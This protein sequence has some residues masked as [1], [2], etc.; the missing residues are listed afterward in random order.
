MTSEQE[1][2]IYVLIREHNS[3]EHGC[4][5]L[6]ENCE[7]EMACLIREKKGLDR[8]FIPRLER[9]KQIRTNGNGS[10]PEKDKP[11]TLA[12]PEDDLERKQRVYLNNVG[13]KIIDTTLFDLTKQERLDHIMLLDRAM[14]DEAFLRIRKKKQGVKN[15]IEKL[16][17]ILQGIHYKE[18]DLIAGLAD[19]AERR[20][21]ARDEQYKHKPV[22]GD[23][24][25]EKKPRTSNKPKYCVNCGQQFTTEPV[26]KLFCKKECSDA[27]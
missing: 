1:Q 17:A 26:D 13:I 10:D 20:L 12:F 2:D 24:T 18:N 8:T 15:A 27:F 16:R 14:R 22:A 25:K 5:H 6:W 7:C 9:E 4:P 11:P 23:G 19:E 21:R 3:V